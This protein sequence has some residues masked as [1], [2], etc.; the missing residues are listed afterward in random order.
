MCIELERRTDAPTQTPILLDLQRL[1]GPL[2]APHRERSPRSVCRVPC[3]SHTS[4]SARPP[5]ARAGPPRQPV[6][7][8]I[9]TEVSRRCAG[10]RAAASPGRRPLRKG[11]RTG[12]R[13]PPV[14]RVVRRGALPVERDPASLDRDSALR[15]VQRAPAQ[16][17]HLRA[18]QPGER[19]PPACG[20]VVGVGRR[21]E[22][23][24]VGRLL[25]MQDTF[26]RRR[27][28]GRLDRRRPR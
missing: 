8:L 28:A 13:T 24:Q 1:A 11:P 2:R 4:T 16:P 25:A 10:R 20:P 14:G 9:G 27:L 22:R 17:E 7:S 18:T 6:R 19:Q 26:P 23:Q 3:L 21:T 5:R 12:R 15:E